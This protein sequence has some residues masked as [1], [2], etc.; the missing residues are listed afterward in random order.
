MAEDKAFAGSANVAA[1]AAAILL[2]Q[3]GSNYPI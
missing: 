3:P 1:E 2:F